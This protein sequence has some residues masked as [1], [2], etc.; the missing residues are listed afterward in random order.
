MCEAV[1]RR[2]PRQVDLHERNERVLV[3]ALP[4]DDTHPFHI[5]LPRPNLRPSAPFR[6]LNMGDGPGHVQKM[7]THSPGGPK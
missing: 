1:P 4:T 7:H 3:G 6:A 2:V 5:P